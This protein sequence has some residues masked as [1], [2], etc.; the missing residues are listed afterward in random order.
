MEIELVID[1]TRDVALTFLVSIKLNCGFLSIEINFFSK[2]IS[3]MP[4][5]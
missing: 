5:I 3:M 2:E 4:K 1:Q